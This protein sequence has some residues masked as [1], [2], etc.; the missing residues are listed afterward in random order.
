MTLK[1]CNR[2]HELIYIQKLFELPVKNKKNHESQLYQYIKIYL[3]NIL[4]LSF[5]FNHNKS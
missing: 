2:V 3:C 5:S 4:A 1:L